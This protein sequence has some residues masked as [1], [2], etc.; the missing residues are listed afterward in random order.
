MVDMTPQGIADRFQAFVEYAACLDGRERS[1]AQVFCDR[2]FQ[3]FGH[4]GYKEAGATL[5]YPVKGRRRTTRFADL[6]WK[7]RVLL[8]MKSRRESLSK[9]FMQAFE[10]WLQLVPQRPRYVV[11]CNFDEFRIYDFDL[12]MDEPVDIVQ[13][14]D[15]PERHS[16]LNFLFPENK[17]PVFG[18]DR[19][20]VTREAAAKIARVFNILTTRGESRSRAQRF[21]L[22][23]VFAMFA[24]DTDLLPRLLFTE[25]LHDCTAGQSTYDLIGGLFTQMNSPH[26]ARGGRFKDVPYFNGGLFTTLDPIELQDEEIELLKSAAMENWS[27]V[28]PAIFGTL[29]QD[30]MDKDERHAFGAHFTTESDIQKVILPT[31]VRPW[32]EQI[33]AAKTFRE[34]R[35]LQR[36]LQSF[37]VLDP[38]CGSGNFLYVAYRELVKLELEILQAIHQGFGTRARDLAGTA[39]LISLTQFF[40]IDNNAFAVELAKVTL[41]LAKRLALIEAR[42]FV[43]DELQQFPLEFE[44]PLPLDNLDDNIR[45]D[46]ALF[47]DWPAA[48]AIIGNPPYQSKNKIKAE[49]GQEYVERV[50]SAYPDVPGRADYCV[51]WFRRAHDELPEGA[52]AG[53]VGTNTIRQNYSREGGTDYIVQNGGV[54][55]EAVSTQVWS[56]TAIVHVSIVNWLKGSQVGKRLLFTQVG[57]QRDSPWD[58]VELDHINAAL[59]PKT[60]VTGAVPLR[61]NEDSETSY[62]GQTHGNAGFLL[63]SAQASI[64]SRDESSES[65]IFP[66]LTGDEMI[67]NVDPSPDRYVI[68]L[69]RCS[70]V[71]SARRHIA[72]FKHLREHV[73]PDII[74][75]AE[76]ERRETGRDTGPRQSHARHW[77]RF[78]R[79]RIKLLDRLTVLP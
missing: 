61:A 71:L 74:A 16:A 21:I 25:L 67:G 19:V 1:E 23:C 73:M 44:S 72:A 34:L 41:I 42:T 45:C 26:R 62:Q 75:S 9:H 37:R 20:E 65:V 10:Y 47:C 7:P 54:I 2:L 40:G 5:E 8:E 14:N 22:Q 52:R 35:S 28:H 43:E 4:L 39:S 51:Y 29:F 70:D 12:Q 32:R 18:N 30:S 64:M 13:I 66:Y 49:L 50:R 11:L 31:I 53:L 27:K 3:A 57:D 24:E 48:N 17:K 69:N 63:T 15:L 60:D 36:K 58:L 78:W 59:S 46:D 55:T 68:D 77:W 6:V 76:T 56:G 79:A 38:A 33:S